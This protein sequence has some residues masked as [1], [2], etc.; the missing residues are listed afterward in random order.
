MRLR[1]HLH[2]LH[3]RGLMMA[4]VLEMAT[5]I[6]PETKALIARMRSE[7]AEDLT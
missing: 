1:G 4:A 6:T 7:V 3:L 5:M 2:T